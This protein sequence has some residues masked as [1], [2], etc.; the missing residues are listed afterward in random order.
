M[1]SRLKES[2]IIAKAVE[3]SNFEDSLKPLSENQINEEVENANKEIIE[4]A[5]NYGTFVVLFS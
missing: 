4:T 1:E 5:Q 3:E 2:E